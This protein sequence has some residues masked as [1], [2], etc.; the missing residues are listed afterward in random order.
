MCICMCVLTRG[1]ESPMCV[2]AVMDGWVLGMG[3]M[4][5]SEGGGLPA[6]GGFRGRTTQHSKQA[7]AGVRDG[8]PAVFARVA[9]KCG[10]GMSLV[11][12]VSPCCV[13]DVAAAPSGRPRPL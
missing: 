7:G 6:E 12:A 4:D 13:A 9:V 3:M 10:R 5:G 11:E 1:T 2:Q 8:A